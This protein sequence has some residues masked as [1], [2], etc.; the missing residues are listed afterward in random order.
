MK[1]FEELRAMYDRGQTR[2]VLNELDET[3]CDSTEAFQ[4][5]VV[6]KGWCYY[7]RNQY[8][9]AHDYAIAAG[10]LP[11]A[12]ELMA[13]LYAYAPGMAN[14]ESLLQIAKELGP[15]NINV[16]NALV[17]RARAKDCSLFGGEHIIELVQQFQNDTSVHAANL[18]HNAGRFFL[19][20]PV[21]P[22]SYHLAVQY[23]DKAINHYGTDKNFHHRARANFWKAHA[24]EK[25]GR[26][27]AVIQAVDESIRLWQEQC[28]LDPTN[29]V[30]W[31]KLQ[32][33]K[34]F[35]IKLFM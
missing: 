20:K 1:S 27:E 29:D 19:D 30:F 35:R 4:N 7:R 28:R 34:D 25:L 26:Q 12:R 11:W 21:G 18:C 31:K 14:D 17:I 33:S 3:R 16:A 13:Y 24:L 23:L 6:L 10:K 8:R 2:D 22:E 32:E 5:L 15:T 9:E